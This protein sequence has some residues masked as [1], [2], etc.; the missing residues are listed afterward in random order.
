MAR[1]V[2]TIVDEIRALLQ[3]RAE[4]EVYL[5]L[6]AELVALAP[7]SFGSRYP[8]GV[9][10]YRGTSDHRSVP[11]AVDELWY[12]PVSVTPVGRANRPGAPVFYCS[13]DPAGA[14]KE[15]GVRVGQLAVHAKWTT[16]APSPA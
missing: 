4:G 6:L 5:T 14:F 10:V 7:L 11:Q 9:E 13:S 1:D 2:G 16:T 12:P 15:I 8:P 3:D